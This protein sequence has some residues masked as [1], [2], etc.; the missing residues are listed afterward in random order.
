MKKI[1]SFSVYGPLAIY[2]DG[3]LENIPL[4]QKYYPDWVCRFY[5]ASDSPCLNRL[6]ELQSDKIEVV[7]MQPEQGIKGM[8]WRFYAFSDPDAERII[9]RDTDQRL[10]HKE[11]VCVDE[12]V[13]SGKKGHKMYETEG[14]RGL[15]L[16]G[17]AFGI[18]GG[19]F[20]NTEQDIDDWIK[21]NSGS[22][23]GHRKINYGLDGTKLVYGADQ[24]YLSEKIWPTIRHDLLLH[25]PETYF[26]PHELPPWG[27]Y[28][29]TRIVPGTNNKEIIHDR[30]KEAYELE[31]R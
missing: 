20:K 18:L 8:F 5:V 27:E 22:E 30:V 10:T 31:E 3:A 21:S 6:K 9:V 25:S 19:L 14:Q 4:A 12:W 29:F 24:V 17:C 28:M 23:I 15:D 16:M 2:N 7:E 26:P 11:K 13:A 1:I